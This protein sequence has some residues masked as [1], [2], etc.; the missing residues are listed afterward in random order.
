MYLNTGVQKWVCSTF[1]VFLS[2]S[3]VQT[4]NQTEQNWFF[5]V[6][7]WTI[8]KSSVHSLAKS[9]KNWTEL[10]QPYNSDVEWYRLAVFQCLCQ[11]HHRYV[12]GAVVWV[13]VVD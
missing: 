4:K 3:P 13:W 5:P 10:W 8:G 9:A 7:F 2:Q 12:S 6:L 11:W 1:F